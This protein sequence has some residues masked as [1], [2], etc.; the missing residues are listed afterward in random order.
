MRVEDS[1][2]PV[3][4]L[5]VKTFLKVPQVSTFTRQ[6]P[7]IALFYVVFIHYYLMLSEPGEGHDI[8]PES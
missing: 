8:V 3:D 7:T 4:L 2:L 5:E 1:C 6:Q